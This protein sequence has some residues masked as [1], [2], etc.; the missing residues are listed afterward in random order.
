MSG[1]ALLGRAVA[2][3]IFL[4]AAASAPA[5]AGRFNNVIVLG[6]SWSDD[7]VKSVHLKRGVE[8]WQINPA[9]LDSASRPAGRFSNGPV[10][11]EQIGSL[12]GIDP[13]LTQNYA[14]G[15]AASGSN[16]E[17]FRPPYEMVQRPERNWNDPNGQITYML[18][19]NGGKLDPDTLYFISIGGNDF[20]EAPFLGWTANPETTKANIV[21]GLARMQAAGARTFMTMNYYGPEGNTVEQT[22]EDAYIQAKKQL[23]VDIVYVD[24][25]SL[26]T[27][28]EQNPETFG[29]DPLLAST[30]CISGRGVTAVNT[31]TPEE[32]ARRM[33]WDGVHP[34]SRLH[35]IFALAGFALAESPVI[36]ATVADAGLLSVQSVQR[37]IAGRLAL[38]RGH[39]VQPIRL[40]SASTSDVPAFDLA[41]IGGRGELFFFADRTFLDRSATNLGPAIDGQASAET[42]GIRFPGATWSFGAAA[43]LIQSEASLPDGSSSDADHILLTA[44]AGWTSSSPLLPAVDLAISAGKANYWS[45]RNPGIAG[46]VAAGSTSAREYAATLALGYELAFDRFTLRPGASLQGARIELDGFTEEGAPAGFNLIVQDQTAD[47]LLGE[48]GVVAE[49]SFALGAFEFVPSAGLHWGREFANDSRS[50]TVAPSTLPDLSFSASTEEGDR[51]YGRVEAGIETALFGKASLRLDY[52]HS[53][54]REDWQT[55]GLRLSLSVPLN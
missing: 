29:M 48:I 12:Y 27:Y 39:K 44:L 8:V 18:A 30:P 55:E 7:G 16:F 24:T 52:A 37:G 54:G 34:T 36:Q 47:S 23:G 25:L 51:N 26:A 22:L 15:G 13:A 19:Q 38:S 45:K 33:S 50:V 2:A 21:D 4:S 35:E 5:E 6:D 43:T 1:F 31:C 41:G 53:L 42:F 49:T 46:T 9:L 32:E 17:P 20:I 40:A 11:A 28:V 10:M 3:G 14:I